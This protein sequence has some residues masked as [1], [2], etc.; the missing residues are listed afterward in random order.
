MPLVRAALGDVISRYLWPSGRHAG[1]GCS[2]SP[3]DPFAT[4]SNHTVSSR[5]GRGMEGCGWS[6]MVSI[7]IPAL[8]ICSF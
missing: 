6:S 3:E 7:S 8:P 1:K 4:T 2:R 5:L